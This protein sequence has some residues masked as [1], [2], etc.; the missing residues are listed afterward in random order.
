MSFLRCVEKVPDTEFVLPRVGDMRG[1][2]R[3]LLSDALFAQTNEALWRQT[4]SA[5]A[6]PGMIGLYVM[7]DTHLGR[8]SG[9]DR[10]SDHPGR[11]RLVS[12]ACSR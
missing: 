9:R 1:L 6:Y 7:P 3:A 11:Q 10:G 8:R 12:T 2:V 5:A 4:A